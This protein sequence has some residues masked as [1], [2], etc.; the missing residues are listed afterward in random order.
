M[1]VQDV[2]VQLLGPPVAVRLRTGGRVRARG[3]G[4]RAFGFVGGCVV[5]KY[6]Q[7][8]VKGGGSVC[9]GWC[10]GVLHSVNEAG[11]GHC[12]APVHERSLTVGSGRRLVHLIVTS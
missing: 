7:W 3:R 11:W 1:L 2:Q 6:L 4:E 10:S 12:R 9:R 5:Q 8:W